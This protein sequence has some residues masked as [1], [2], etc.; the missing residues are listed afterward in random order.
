MLKT[1]LHLRSRWA[2]PAWLDELPDDHKAIVATGPFPRL[3]RAIASAK[4]S[5]ISWVTV[6]HH[7]APY[8]HNGSIFFLDCGAGPFAVTAGHVYRGYLQDLAIA[9]RMQ[10]Q[11]GDLEFDP[12]ARLIEQRV[13]PDIATFR[14]SLEEIRTMGKEVVVHDLAAWPPAPLHAGEAVIVGGFPAVERIERLRPNGMP[15]EINFGYYYCN[16]PLTTVFN[17]QLTCRFERK[18]WVNSF[19]QGL[20]AAGLDLGGISGAPLLRP[21]YMHGKWQMLLAGVVTEAMCDPQWE[22]VKTASAAYLLSDGRIQQQL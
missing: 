17:D 10:C 21:A 6:P 11:I 14:I 16:T 18:Y 12:T 3:L 20:P 19:G 4:V 7:G 1:W 9:R 8:V 2:T 13:Q 22:E 5:P 15:I